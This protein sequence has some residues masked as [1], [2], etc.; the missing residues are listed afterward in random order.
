ME[1]ITINNFRKINRQWDINLS[2]ITFFVGTNNSGKSSVLKALMLLDGFGNSKNHFELNFNGK[3]SRN[4]KID[5][6]T[7]A[8]N[9]DN[10][11]DKQFDIKFSVENQDFTINY[12]FYPF[13]DN[14]GMFEK[15]KLKFIEFINKN[16]NSKLSCKHLA[17]DEY[18]ITVDNIFIFGRNID[19]NKTEVE[20][21]KYVILKQDIESKIESIQKFFI[22]EADF[23]EHDLIFHLNKS[24]ELKLL[25]SKKSEINKIINSLKKNKSTDFFQFN[26]TF[27]L[28]DYYGYESFDRI[29]RVV[30]SK[31]FHENET[32]F[33]MSS[34]KEMI[35][36]SMVCENLLNVLNFNISH[37]TPNR[38]TQTRLYVNENGS[39]DINNIIKYHSE[40][41]IDK[42][43]AAAIFLRHW[44]KIFD[45]GEDFIIKSI[46]GLA[47]II[48]IKE[49]KDWINLVDK[50]FGAGQVF[51]ILLHI[52]TVIN[53]INIKR[54]VRFRSYRRGLNKIKL[55]SKIIIIEEPE[56]N[57]HPRLQSELSKM[58]Y[59]VWQ[60]YRIQFIVETHSEYIIRK[61]QLLFLEHTKSK[62]NKSYFSQH[63]SPFAVYYF[64]KDGPYEMKYLD[65]GK[66]DR[67]F[68]EG[69]Y[70]EASK[71]T[72]S[73]IQNQR[74]KD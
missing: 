48:E 57:L 70:D 23:E 50:G 22:K 34:T 19:E 63:D 15:G 29:L 12:I 36:V 37:L 71:H 38:N 56:A 8:I 54:S 39:N 73:L 31:Y 35:R 11:Q 53:E 44:M 6:Y 9:R 14:D 17:S 72:M 26:P 7:N 62:N 52:A 13:D 5:C 67:N 55:E 43:S 49:G 69:F 60:E 32:K 33:G 16:N 42:K 10:F 65:S 68:G 46:E 21:N 51:T 30:I 28:S 59:E 1:K 18:Q 2:P 41:L 20:L 45:I 47:S 61:S 4:H 40:N 25:M 3:H 64:D 27:K 74:K 24:N 66:F 58:L